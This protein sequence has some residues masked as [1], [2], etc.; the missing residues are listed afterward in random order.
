MIEGYCKLYADDSKIIRVIED[1]SIAD[2]L[3]RDI[4]SVTNWTKEWPMKLNSNKCKVMQF[5]NKNARPVYFIYDLST[6]QRIYLEVSECKRDLGVIVS[7][8]LIWNKHASNIASKANKVL[9][10][11]VKNKT[12]RDV[13]LW[14]QLYISLV[15][16]HLEFASSVLNPYPQIVREI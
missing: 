13:D 16:P 15:R 4:E 3:K 5:G 12:Y 6:G 11:L 9:G 10:M 2:T 7:L 8:D 1:Y 14:K